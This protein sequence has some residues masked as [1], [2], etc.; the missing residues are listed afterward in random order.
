MYIQCE[1]PSQHADA[2]PGAAAGINQPGDQK[3]MQPEAV[4]CRA[5]LIGMS[6]A[7]TTCQQTAAIISRPPGSSTD[8]EDL[9]RPLK[10]APRPSHGQMTMDG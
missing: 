4:V 7:G 1:L 9:L 2:L 5:N 8:L 3:P 10:L 6:H